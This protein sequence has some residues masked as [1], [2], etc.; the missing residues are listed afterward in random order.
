[1]HAN[2][3]FPIQ[4]PAQVT[5]AIQA[6][7]SAKTRVLVL[8]HITSPTALILPIAEITAL[9][10]QQGIQVLIDGAHGPGMV[11][12]DL[13]K[14]G[15]DWYT[16]NCHKW[17]C[18]AKGCAFLW[19]HPDLAASRQDIHPVVISHQ[20]DEP[21][22]AEFDAIGTRDYSAWLSVGEALRFH[23]K[24][25]GAELRQRNRRL[26]LEGAEL[27]RSELHQE[28][29]APDSMLGSIVTLRWPEEVD[30]TVEVAARLRRELW[31]E[32]R[33]EVAVFAFDGQIYFRISAQAYNELADYQQLA[34]ALR[35]RRGR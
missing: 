3:P 13:L 33:V 18:S 25:G 7:L 11:N 21:W 17:L 15:S 22:P 2:V 14:I 23:Q 31:A 9:C 24:L 30:A 6:A 16:G 28:A 5:A 10:Q 4:E 1:M 27:L 35:N 8:D 12:L 20:L 26:A 32:H 19:A 34:V 29:L